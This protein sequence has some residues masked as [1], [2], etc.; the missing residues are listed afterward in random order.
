MT[1]TVLKPRETAIFENEQKSRFSPNAVTVGLVGAG[2]DGIITFSADATT[3]LDSGVTIH[4]NMGGSLHALNLLEGS[5]PTNDPPVIDDGSYT[6]VN[7]GVINPVSELAVMLIDLNDGIVDYEITIMGT[8]AADASISDVLTFGG[9]NPKLQF[10]SNGPYKTVTDIDGGP[11]TGAFTS[12]DLLRVVPRLGTS[13]HDMV[14]RAHDPYFTHA[15]M[16]NDFNESGNNDKGAYVEAADVADKEFR[17]SLPALPADVVEVEIIRIQY[18]TKNIGAPLGGGVDFVLRHTGVNHIV[19][20]NSGT[21][22]ES[23]LA[24][25]SAAIAL[26]LAPGTGNPWTLAQANSLELGCIFRGEDPTITKQCMRIRCEMEVKTTSTGTVSLLVADA[27]LEA[28]SGDPFDEGASDDGKFLNWYGVQNSNF[29]LAYPSLEVEAIAVLNV[30]AFW[31][32]ATIHLGHPNGM[33]PN[34][35]NCA[36]GGSSGSEAPSVQPRGG[37]GLNYG[38]GPIEQSGLGGIRMGLQ[39]PGGSEEFFGDESG[40]RIL[41]GPGNPTGGCGFIS[42]LQGGR[43]LQWGTFFNKS[44]VL[45]DLPGATTD[46]WTLAGFNGIE[47]VMEIGGRDDVIQWSKC[48]VEPEWLRN[49]TGDLFLHLVLRD[50][51]DSPNDLTFM[52]SQHPDNKQ[53]GCTFAGIDEATEINSISGTV[54]G[55]TSIGATKGWKI[56]LKVGATT[57]DEIGDPE[58]MN[59]DPEDRTA[60]WPQHPTETRPWTRAEVNSAILIYEAQGEN[61]YFPKFLSNMG[62]TIDFLGIPAKLDTARRLGSEILLFQG[63]PVPMLELRV[64]FVMGDLKLMTDFS[65][66]KD[67]IPSV[68]KTL[69]IEK[70]ERA[71][72]RLFEKELDPNTDTWLIRGYDLRDFLLTFLASFQA[73]TKGRSF[74]GM[75]LITPGANLQ[76]ER[77][78]NDYQPDPFADLVQELQS[79]E[80]AINTDGILITNQGI[81][82]VINSAFGEGAVD[83]FDGWT[84]VGLPVAG[85]QI[86]E[87][88]RTALLPIIV[89]SVEYQGKSIYDEETGIDR[90]VF[91]VGAD[92]PTDIYLEREVTLPTG[93]GLSPEGGRHQL[94]IT[95][96]DPTG[97]PLSVWLRGKPV[98]TS[99]KNFDPRNDTWEVANPTWFTLPVR[100]VPT[101]DRIITPFATLHNQAQPSTGLPNYTFS[102]RIGVRTSA[103]QVNRVFDAGTEGG[104][105]LSGDELMFTRTRILSRTGPVVRD[106]AKLFVNNIS[107]TPVYFL[108][109]GTGFAVIESLWDSAEL[110][111]APGVKRYLFGMT[112]TGTT[113]EELYYDVD[114]EEFVYK[115]TIASVVFSAT[116]KHRGIA[117]DVPIRVSWRWISFEGDLGEAP[118]STQIFINDERGTDGAANSSPPQPSNVPLFIGSF[119]GTNGQMLDGRIRRMRITQQALPLDRIKKL[120]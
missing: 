92:A 117:K 9:A 54:R 77:P 70:W 97:H 110:P 116:K 18:N 69:G 90:S 104:T 17:I 95:H 74:D 56:K 1:I 53:F 103:N 83:V 113:F 25:P 79:N 27:I 34:T 13:A 107:D 26:S 119:D 16:E 102:C 35:E 59:T 91:M 7:D 73:V 63:Q 88:N 46:P 60:V 21:Q 42:G 76:F 68:I 120:R 48:Y 19:G 108:R 82:R 47:S 86:V 109:R 22:A 84:K 115:R 50:N 40:A 43:N 98:G 8:D 41:A 114:D 30:K 105:I 37:T 20:N 81:N 52:S 87:S 66:T 45:N 38:E 5:L 32:G 80:P 36:L 33:T 29:E 65:V 2:F 28:M 78:T 75:S 15:E 31:R 72:F 99:E 118:F 57:F 101:R 61:A 11:I 24:D 106:A 100:S 14:M 112:I 23:T 4:N 6:L 96:E 93:F 10:T 39:A 12:A 111:N 58:Y 49:P 85:A 71:L 51:L 55:W 3:L 89:N 64:P 67:L 44:A 62:L 94:T